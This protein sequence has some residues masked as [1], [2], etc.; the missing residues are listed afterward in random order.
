M[1]PKRI[2]RNVLPF[3]IIATLPFVPQAKADFVGSEACSGCHSDIFRR[4]SQTPHANAIR[5]LYQ[6]GN[7]ISAPWKGDLVLSEKLVIDVPVRITLSKEDGIYYAELHDMK[8]PGKSRKL[9]VDQVGGTF[10]ARERY[11]HKDEAT[12]RTNVLPLDWNMANQTFLLFTPTAWWGKDGSLLDGVRAQRASKIISFENK[13]SGCH[14]TGI[15][16]TWEI[17]PLVGYQTVKS[18]TYRELNIGCEKCHGPGSTHVAQP[19]SGN[20]VKPSAIGHERAIEICAQCHSRGVSNENPNTTFPYRFTDPLKAEGYLPGKTFADY[21]KVKP[22]RWAGTDISKQHH[23]QYEDYRGSAHARGGM[24]CASCHD[25][26]GTKY[27]HYLKLEA[28]DDS[29]CLSCHRSK[30]AFADPAVIDKHKG[31][32]HLTGKGVPC[33]SCH[34]PKT[35]FGTNRLEARF[36]SMRIITPQESLKHFDLINPLTSKDPVALNKWAQIQKLGYCYNPAI[37]HNSLVGLCL[38]FDVL[39]NACS[40]CHTDT[41]PILGQF[42]TDERNKL[43]AGENLYLRLKKQQK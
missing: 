4:W 18:Q 10:S 5:P 30:P 42:S 21:L 19:A 39:P 8:N 1:S 2:L 7:H 36:H 32:G 20:I 38:E 9:R 25:P 27:K 15:H 34:M 23:Q 13:C 22:T 41:A 29:L 40:A 12:G 35:V 33:I 43:V 16:Y 6:G 37:P 26:H 17:D 24:A 3:L 11:Y 28:S 31:P 14:N